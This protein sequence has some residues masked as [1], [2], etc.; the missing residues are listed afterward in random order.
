[1][2]GLNNLKRNNMVEGYWK[3]EDRDARM[4]FY[5]DVILGLVYYSGI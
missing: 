3:K 4:Y 5:Y 1:M 2:N